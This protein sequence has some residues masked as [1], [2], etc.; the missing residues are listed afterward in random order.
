MSDKDTDGVALKE[1]EGGAGDAGP[2][3]GAENPVLEK[4]GLAAV[5]DSDNPWNSASS[6]G[7]GSDG[8]AS[9]GDKDEPE[10]GKPDAAAEQ[11]AGAKEAGAK[12]AG[13]KDAHGKLDGSKAKDDGKPGTGEDNDKGKDAKPVSQAVQDLADLD[14]SQLKELKDR[15]TEKDE[16]G[17]SLK[18]HVWMCL[19]VACQVFL[20][21]WIVGTLIDSRP[22]TG[23]SVA[24]VALA[25]LV[26]FPVP[27]WIRVPTK[28]GLAFLGVALAFLVT[29]FHKGDVHLIPA[30]PISLVWALTA[31][32]LWVAVLV[33]VLKVFFAK[34]RKASTV[35]IVLLI[36]PAVGLLSALVSYFGGA[37]PDGFTFKYLNS[38]PFALTTF[39]PWFIEPAMFFDVLL[40]LAAAAVFFR[41]E[42]RVLSNPAIEVKQHAGVFL[43]LGCLV[44]SL[45][46]F[47]FDATS[48]DH[49]TGL[50]N[51]I[52]SLAP[53]GNFL[54]REDE[55]V[56]VEQGAAAP[57]VAPAV[58]PAAPLAPPEPVP[59]PPEASA[60]SDA[61]P[62]AP[63][64]STPAAPEA[65]PAA[66]V[67]EPAATPEP[68]PAAPGPA[69]GQSEAP[70][71]QEA[72]SE[73]R[74]AAPAPAEPAPPAPGSP[75]TD[76]GP[77]APSAAAPAV[78][79]GVA[80]GLAAG[81][82]AGPG[83]DGSPEPAHPAVAPDGTGA[84]AAPGQEE[85]TA[86]GLPVPA[87]IP[88][89]SLT[90]T[91]GA[92]AEA[93]AETDPA[94][95]GIVAES[96][97]VSAEVPPEAGS[98]PVGEPREPVA[99]PAE[100]PDTDEPIPPENLPDIVPGA[101][102][103]PDTTGYFDKPTAPSPFQL[104]GAGADAAA[105]PSA[106]PGAGEAA[107]PEASGTAPA[108]ASAAGEPIPAEAAQAGQNV[109]GTFA[110]PA[111]DG[112]EVS[113]LRSENDGLRAQLSVQQ[114]RIEE[115]EER[116]LALER[117]LA[118]AV[119]DARPEAGQG[120]GGR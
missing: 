44:L 55:A 82:A 21:F 53:T 36:Y 75:V 56:P 57:P 61:A 13:A 35:M 104:Q 98:V 49:A 32:A 66:P 74:E 93:P 96:V 89:G 25:I 107:S 28:A 29:S 24:L 26:S 23:L 87:E 27:K 54:W 71:A 18:D 106:G 90:S 15:K 31:M 91:G 80:G 59:A 34:G 60:A 64:P 43:G 117:I 9:G 118:L 8:S 16:S 41:Y 94:Q 58:E 69:H 97:P 102:I 105:E 6:N 62:T 39:L 95:A 78:A 33:T 30:L 108:G 2:E 116:V 85:V 119:A 52:K 76:A 37:A 40:P 83:A 77:D 42:I 5:D 101:T 81:L 14:E 115:L 68:V 17:A 46:G 47:M 109:S 10:P 88:A 113:D 84:G 110:P 11:E 72:P 12:E 86:G 79:G 48:G 65:A 7:K 20:I 112:S 50:T 45:A 19:L 67:V 38:S 99:A 100:A 1:P 103:G 114:G 51:S 111:S 63:E 73:A 92:P 3:D 4:D 120:E 22:Y 70:V